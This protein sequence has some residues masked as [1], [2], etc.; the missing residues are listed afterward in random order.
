VRNE[1]ALRV[2]TDQL[3]SEVEQ[4]TRERDRIWKVSED[5]LGVSNFDGYFI[6]V[7]PA[8]TT[9]LGWSE[10]EIRA[11][12][13]SQLRHPDDAPAAE[14]GRARLAQ[15]VTNVRME[16]RFRHRDGS[17]RWLAWTLRV[18]D[19]LIYVSGRNITAQK[20]AAAALHESERQ[21]GSLV[22][23][24]TDYALI[25]LDPDGIVASW[26]AGAER[27]KGYAAHEIV[28][29]HFSQFY[30]EEDRANGVPARDRNRAHNRKVRGRGPAPA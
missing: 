5:L 19:G 21:F 4:R 8:W 27:I 2:L 22:G 6:S 14:A 28:G 24:V 3:E 11:L 16:N 1:K 12:H 23:G 13:V 17:W 30:T 18:D 25:M 15:G 9:L 20:Q 29:R 7:N 10:A 26:N